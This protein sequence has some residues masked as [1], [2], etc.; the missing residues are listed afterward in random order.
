M[1]IHV[2]LSTIA[3]SASGQGAHTAQEG[4]REMHSQCSTPTMQ[5]PGLQLTFPTFPFHV[6]V[7]LSG[8]YK[9]G[10]NISILSGYRT[11]MKFPAF[12]FPG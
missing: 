10:Y 7:G 3:H 4:S 1:A 5:F 2:Q 12:T 11:M 9:Q 6:N 8:W